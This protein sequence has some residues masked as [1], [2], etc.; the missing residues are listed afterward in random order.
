MHSLWYLNSRKSK[1]KCTFIKIQLYAKSCIECWRIWG[2]GVE[3]RTQFHYY[4]NNKRFPSWM[5][6]SRQ[7][8]TWSALLEQSLPLRPPPT[9]TMAQEQSWFEE[10]RTG[11]C[12]RPSLL[13]CIMSFV[14]VR[15]FDFRHI[16]LDTVFCSLLFPF[17]TFSQC[18]WD[19]F[20]LIQADSFKEL[21]SIPYHTPYF[22]FS[23]SLNSALIEW[24]I[25]PSVFF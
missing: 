17:E 5:D 9:I 11:F 16:R 25:I 23:A 15:K 22:L 24:S 21:F 1:T 14:C 4:C 6:L 2:G 8:K 7:Q 13:N 20:I 3:K 19:L 12:T 18:V 10:R